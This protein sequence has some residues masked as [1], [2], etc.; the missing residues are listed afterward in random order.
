ML[1][2]IN[3]VITD[4]LSILPSHPAVNQHLKSERAGR[5]SKR[6]QNKQ[7]P[8]SASDRL[9]QKPRIINLPNDRFLLNPE[10][11]VAG[12][13]T[14]ALYS[15]ISGP[16]KQKVLS[17]C[18]SRRGISTLPPNDCWAG[19]L[20]GR[21]TGRAG[22]YT[23]TQVLEWL[24]KDFNIYRMTIININY[25]SWNQWRCE[26]VPSHNPFSSLIWIHTSN[27]LVLPWK[28]GIK[29][30]C[31]SAKE[32][33]LRLLHTHTHTHTRHTHTHEHTRTHTNTHAV[34]KHTEPIQTQ[35][36]LSPPAHLG[37]REIR[38]IL[39]IRTWLNIDTAE[40]SASE[41]NSLIWRWKLSKC[42]SLSQKSKLLKSSLQSAMRSW[43]K[44]FMMRFLCIQHTECF[45]VSGARRYHTVK[46]KLIETLSARW[47]FSPL[48]LGNWHFQS[49]CHVAVFIWISFR[50]S[51]TF[52]ATENLL[53]AFFFFHLRS[54]ED[55][56]T[57]SLSEVFTRKDADEAVSPLD[58]SHY[59]TVASGSRQRPLLLAAD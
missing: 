28:L 10:W 20:V 6:R 4:G 56:R 25:S 33:L 35:K 2:S 43:L 39:R 3:S 12:E 17:W 5:S 9:Q 51:L 38:S 46:R 7:S 55:R 13:V 30:V 15:A 19:R 44:P 34:T 40:L 49:D 52:H 41:R 16:L 8:R 31:E 11:S 23:R 48:L 26:K 14:R 58:A 45:R 32:T 50:S 1:H 29:P 18:W 53:Y 36:T 27:E 42:P 37:H 22:N 57:S 54:G 59:H 47:S 21:V 24:W